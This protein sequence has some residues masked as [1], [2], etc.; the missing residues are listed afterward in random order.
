[1]RSC[2]GALFSSTLSACRLARWPASSGAPQQPTPPSSCPARSSYKCP[3][4][5]AP[6][7]RFKAYS[8]GGKNDAKSM[9]SRMAT[10]KK[11]GKGAPSAAA[12]FA[13]G[14]R[15]GGG[16]PASMGA[17]AGAQLEGGGW[18]S[19]KLAADGSHAAAESP[20]CAAAQLAQ[21]PAR[22]PAPPNPTT[23]CTRVAAATTRAGCWSEPWVA[24]C[25]WPL[26][27]SSSARSTTESRGR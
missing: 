10:L 11:G 22:V 9:G 23:A 1:L 24:S 26:S 16:G 7:R 4:C 15:L 20:A 3:V 2:P 21:W 5:Q 6:K 19:C 27:T 25:C 17:Q 8:G 14:A 12:R 18:G 13:G